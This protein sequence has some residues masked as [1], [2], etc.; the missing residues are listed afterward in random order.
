MTGASSEILSRFYSEAAT[1]ESNI[2]LVLMQWRRLHCSGIRSTLSSMTYRPFARKH[3]ASLMSTLELAIS[4]IEENCDEISIA[5]NCE[6]SVGNHFAH[7]KSMFREVF[8]SAQLRELVA[9]EYGE[10]Q[11]L[12]SFV[13]EFCRVRMEELKRYFEDNRRLA[14]EALEAT[15]N[16]IHS[17]SNKSKS[18]TML[19]RQRSQFSDLVT[20]FWAHST[21]P[22]YYFAYDRS[23]DRT[24]LLTH[25]LG[26]RRH[27]DLFYSTA[28]VFKP[29]NTQNILYPTYCYQEQRHK[30]CSDLDIFDLGDLIDSVPKIWAIGSSIGL[31]QVLLDSE[32]ETYRTDLFKTETQAAVYDFYMFNRSSFS[33]SI[34]TAKGKSSP[35]Q[36]EGVLHI[37]SCLGESFRR[38][39]VFFSNQRRGANS[40]GEWIRSEW[41]RSGGQTV[42]AILSRDFRS[43]YLEEKED[44]NSVIGRYHAS[45]AEST[46]STT[47]HEIK[48]IVN[49]L[50]QFSAQASKEIVNWI[51]E[52]PKNGDLVRLKGLQAQLGNIRSSTSL[53]SAASR[54]R[55]HSVSGQDYEIESARASEDFPQIV[56]SCIALLAFWSLSRYREDLEIEF[57]NRDF[58]ISSTKEM[59]DRLQIGGSAIRDAESDPIAS[60][61]RL[62]EHCV[63]RVPEAYILSSLFEIFANWRHISKYRDIPN[64]NRKNKVGIGIYT[65][66]GRLGQPAFDIIQCHAIDKDELAERRIRGGLPRGLRKV[67]GKYGRQGLGLLEISVKNWEVIKP[68]EEIEDATVGNHSAYMKYELRVE[69]APT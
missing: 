57:K 22:Y 26:E 56:A 47:V 32:I 48:E 19:H 34:Q 13:D 46:V 14:L 53:I 54:I 21:W 66:T 16:L 33:L 10:Q 60:V 15:Q 24:A 62:M 52:R 20:G 42:S 69:L 49:N 25:I 4:E 36:T 64:P 5:S 39:L 58:L 23:D 55:L 44:E 51:D 59:A 18:K 35:V 41:R 6:R 28:S 7:M 17:L 50:G 29:D 61:S 63:S 31:H 8:D 65:V 43:R 30:D 37:C 3:L 2:S 40:E 1:F 11:T 12:D 45:V 27:K 38:L 68:P 67:N 9:Q